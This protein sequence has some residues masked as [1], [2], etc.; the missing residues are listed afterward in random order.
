MT[1]HLIHTAAAALVALASIPALPSPVA[2][3]PAARPETP[4]TTVW[5][6]LPGTVAPGAKVVVRTR[7]GEVAVGRVRSLSDT[8]I[9]IESGQLRTIPA[10][11]VDTIESR[12]AG[13]RVKNFAGRGLRVG[14][15]L[16][17]ILAFGW[18]MQPH[19]GPCT[20]DDC[21]TGQDALFGMVF[22][23]AAGT[24]IG[25]GVGLLI[26]GERRVLY[27]RG[28]PASVAIAPIAGQ[29]RRG[30]QLRMVF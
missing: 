11:A 14:A 2:A 24:A 29:G 3:Q 1:R 5:A 17:G 20:S 26:P 23:P 15:A 21:L 27:A 7:D 25:A 22:F 6:S 30:A 18:L 19:D 16:G 12:R 9:V 13:R 10:V 4:L 8:A 28:A